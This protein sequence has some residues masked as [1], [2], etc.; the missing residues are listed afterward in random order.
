MFDSPLAPQ[1]LRR[2]VVGVAEHEAAAEASRSGNAFD[3]AGRFCPLEG[4][5]EHLWLHVCLVLLVILAEVVPQLGDGGILGRVIG[6]DG[7][8]DGILVLSSALLGPVDEGE[9]AALSGAGDAFQLTP[10]QSSLDCL[11]IIVPF[12]RD[13]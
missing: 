8:L 1:L 7:V 2:R 5:Q 6:D 3:V 9:C 13:L 10:F 4:L 11:R 12:V